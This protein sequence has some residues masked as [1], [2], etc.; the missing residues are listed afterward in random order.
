MYCMSLKE[1]KEEAGHT[2]TVSHWVLHSKGSVA[3]AALK[4]L[5]C[6]VKDVTHYVRN[7]PLP[8]KLCD[9]V[10]RQSHTVSSF[11]EVLDIDIESYFF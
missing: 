3:L 10:F 1:Y 2:H 11:T 6:F 8:T 5:C 4:L 7:P 9:D